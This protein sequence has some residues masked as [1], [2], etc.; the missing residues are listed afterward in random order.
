MMLDNK[1]SRTDPMVREQKYSAKAITGTRQTGSRRWNREEHVALS[2][3]QSAYMT[4]PGER[5][6]PLFDAWEML[7]YDLAFEQIDPHA[8]RRCHTVS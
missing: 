1:I 8:N 5:K 2:L 4:R 3:Y 6:Q 7:Q